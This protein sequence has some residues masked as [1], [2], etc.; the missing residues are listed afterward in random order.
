M[1]PV[2]QKATNVNLGLTKNGDFNFLHPN[3]SHRHLKLP[4]NEKKSLIYNPK[5]KILPKVL[6]EW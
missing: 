1:G 5:A 2:A 4:F 3:Q 6:F